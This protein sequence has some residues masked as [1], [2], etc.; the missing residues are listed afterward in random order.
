MPLLP[1]VLGLRAR[2]DRNPRFVA[3]LV[4]RS[5]ADT[6]VQPL[7]P[8]RRRSRAAGT[9]AEYGMMNAE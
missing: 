9:T 1:D 2:G 3:R 5:L 4:A 7:A 8:G 6:A